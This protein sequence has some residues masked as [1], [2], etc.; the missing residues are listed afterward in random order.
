LSFP[1]QGWHLTLLAYVLSFFWVFSNLRRIPREPLLT[2]FVNLGRW[3]G[4]LTLLS[5][6]FIPYHLFVS[7]YDFLAFSALA[8]AFLVTLSIA[9]MVI[10]DRLLPPRAKLLRKPGCEEG[11]QSMLPF[12]E[13]PVMLSLGAV[14]ASLLAMLLTPDLKP[15]VSKSSAGQ[16]L[17][18]PSPLFLFTLLSSI[19][20]ILLYPLARRKIV[21]KFREQRLAPGSPAELGGASAKAVRVVKKEIADSGFLTAGIGGV[22]L[23]LLFLLL[24][25][26]P[27]D[28]FSYTLVSPFWYI[29]SLYIAWRLYQAPEAY[30]ATK[31]SK[32]L[33]FCCPRCGGREVEPHRDSGDLVEKYIYGR[34]G[35]GGARERVIISHYRHEHTRYEDERKRLKK[36][37]RVLPGAGQQA[38]E[39]LRIKYSEEARRL[40]IKDGLLKE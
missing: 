14:T 17:Y 23:S 37:A 4:A 35:L 33:S 6:L 9:L 28:S 38:M 26:A 1:V 32:E 27:V 13:G 18:D 2:L 12:A 3:A 7:S 40:A 20:L 25:P 29:L 22:I 31:A 34:I 24:V 10:G 30:L 15:H 5:L 19:A 39:E 21:G 36:L 8:G 16:L 11:E